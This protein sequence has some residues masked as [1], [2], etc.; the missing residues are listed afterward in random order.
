PPEVVLLSN[1]VNQGGGLVVF[2]GDRVLADAYNEAFVS[3]RNLGDM[4]R[5]VALQRAAQEPAPEDRAL[6]PA[7]IGEL[8]TGENAGIDPLEYRHPIV[9]AFRG[10]ERA[11]L[12][13]TPIMSYLRLTP[14]VEQGAQ[15]A[16]A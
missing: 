16:L 11:G 8:V 7:A 1:Y 5:K 6:L 10:R 3:Q 9:A 15:V 14:H 2:L 13:T 12:L 4:V